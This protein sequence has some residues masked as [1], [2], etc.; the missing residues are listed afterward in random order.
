MTIDVWNIPILCDDA[1]AIN[2][3]RRRVS[4]AVL[5]MDDEV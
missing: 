2:R 5:A 3:K 1:V 4:T